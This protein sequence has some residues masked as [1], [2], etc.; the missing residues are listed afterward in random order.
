MTQLLKAMLAA[1]ACALALASAMPAQA[2]VVLAATRVVYNASDAEATLR[3]SNEGDSPMLTQSWLDKGDA[4]ASPSTIDVPFTV[5]PP[6]SRIDPGKAQT[7]RILYTGEPLP[8]DRES[9]F[10]LNVLEVPPKPDASGTDTNFL[11]M[12]FRSRIKLFFRP[13]GLKG[14]A[15]DAPSQLV[16]RLVPQGGAGKGPALEARN[17]TAYHVSL[18]T[19]ELVG[20]GKSAKFDDGVMVAPGEAQTIALTGELPS[21]AQATVK[22][23]AINDHGGVLEGESSLAP[24]MSASGTP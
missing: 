19:V 10:W 22:Y 5:M 7:L 16:W 17:P 13:E 11:Q 20:G 12:A 18:G 2:A 9:V 14:Q 4:T 15:A 3:L 8:R 6:V 21:T 1:G 23:Q 24:A